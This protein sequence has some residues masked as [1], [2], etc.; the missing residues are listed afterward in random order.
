MGM[1]KKNGGA[2]EMIRVS[3]DVQKL[4]AE[5]QA[6]LWA[7]GK[8]GPRE[9]ELLASAS[10]GSFVKWALEDALFLHRSKVK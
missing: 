8:K 2:V 9:L 5:Y 3:V 1:S 10:K 6:V 4:L 7:K